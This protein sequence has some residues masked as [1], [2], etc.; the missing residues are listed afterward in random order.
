[1]KRPSSKYCPVCKARKLIF[2]E[3]NLETCMCC[4]TVL[5]HSSNVYPGYKPVISCRAD[6]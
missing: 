6:E 1:M 4:Q 3:G 2:I 5:R